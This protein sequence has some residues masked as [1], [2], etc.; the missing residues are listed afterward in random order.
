M[1][2]LQ[3]QTSFCF[4]PFFMTFSKFLWSRSENT[5]VLFFFY[6]KNFQFFHLI[7][8]W[9]TDCKVLLRSAPK[10]LALESLVQLNTEDVLKKE[11]KII[12]NPTRNLYDYR[13]CRMRFRS[14][15]CKTEDNCVFF[16]LVNNHSSRN[17]QFTVCIDW[18]MH[19]NFWL[20]LFLKLCAV[21]YCWPAPDWLSYLY[22]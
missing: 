20:F 21:G 2:L 16:R 12:N 3:E 5:D 17:V 15:V 13:S 14:P 4:M 18:E 6:W 11:C 22:F 10:W 8:G 9:R 19:W 7:A 1:I